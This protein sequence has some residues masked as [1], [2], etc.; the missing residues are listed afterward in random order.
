MVV[1]DNG[2]IFI[3]DR[4]E[5]CRARV[6]GIKNVAIVDTTGST[7]K[8]ISAALTGK[9]AVSYGLAIKIAQML[10]TT[11]GYLTGREESVDF[12]EE[13]PHSEAAEMFAKLMKKLAVENPDLIIHFRDL[14][15]NMDNLSP[16]D[17]QAIADGIALI[18]GKANKEVEKRLRKVELGEL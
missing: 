15:K 11:V 4:V 6:G 18:T 12:P 14:E 16:K 3:V 17:V 1:K 10:G 9:S 7:A 2:I 8:H 5:E 13:R